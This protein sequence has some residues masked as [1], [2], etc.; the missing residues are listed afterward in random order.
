MHYLQLLEQASEAYE[1]SREDI[2]KIYTTTV[3]EDGKTVDPSLL[4]KLFDEASYLDHSRQ[5]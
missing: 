2:R 3:S 1:R 5:R 4:E